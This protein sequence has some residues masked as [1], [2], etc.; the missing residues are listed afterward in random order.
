MVYGV[1]IGTSEKGNPMGM[2]NLTAEWTFDAGYVEPDERAVG[3]L[4]KPPAISYIRDLSWTLEHDPNYLS[5]HDQSVGLRIQSLLSKQGIFWDD[6][7]FQK[8]FLKIVTAAVKRVR[9][10]DQ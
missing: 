1:T 2:F 3:A 5:F 4:L 9:N 10:M 7:I 8:Q 6:E